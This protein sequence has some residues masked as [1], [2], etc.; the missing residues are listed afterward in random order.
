MARSGRKEEDSL[1]KAVA[2]SIM[3]GKRLR[4]PEALRCEEIQKRS[5]RH[6]ESIRT[7]VMNEEIHSL[8]TA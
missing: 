7:S 5:D 6:K 1:T 8:T 3:T 2:R 4:V